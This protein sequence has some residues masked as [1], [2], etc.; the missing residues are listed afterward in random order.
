MYR[1]VWIYAHVVAGWPLQNVCLQ[2]QLAITQTVSNDFAFYDSAHVQISGQ[3]SG[4]DSAVSLIPSTANPN[5][6]EGPANLLPAPGKPY[7]LDIVVS[8]D[9]SGS[10]RTS[11]YT[12]ST[13][14][15]SHF[16]IAEVQALV[17]AQ[18]DTFLNTP[19]LPT[20]YNALFNDS[21]EIF[22][23]NR[24][25]W[26]AFL[27]KNQLT[28]FAIL[29]RTRAPFSEEDTLI[30]LNPPLDLNAHAVVTDYSEDVGGI[31]TTQFFGD[32]AGKG[33]SSFHGF[34]GGPPDSTQKWEF[35][36]THR[37]DYTPSLEVF[38]EANMM[39][40]L[41]ISNA[42]LYVGDTKFF[43]FATD[44]NYWPYVSNSIRGADD[45]R[46]RPTSNITHGQGV[47]VGM[48][49]DSLTLHTRALP[50]SVVWPYSRTSILACRSN[51]WEDSKGACQERLRDFC[52]DSLSTAA[53]CR[54]TAI[55]TALDSG[56]A[57]N[58]L[59]LPDTDQSVL[60][61]AQAMGERRQCMASDFP[62]ESWCEIPRN[63]CLVSTQETACKQELW[64]WCINGGWPIE[65]SYACG[66]G[67]VS[68]M[69]LQNKTSPALIHARDQWCATHKSDSQC[70]I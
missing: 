5:C 40:T 8:W 28:M 58:A 24:P 63:D 66:S 15:P 48:V 21:L 38:G 37:L 47:F 36:H 34:F 10:S 22:K 43:F 69:R 49:V 9:S 20:E 42:Y 53:D 27:F 26:D 31:L 60:D 13:K 44:S 3:F 61:S 16:H 59:M 70:K 6:F 55:A 57:W 30:L 2:P 62:S 51:N 64:D 41:F 4:H 67:L 54:T 32:D 23:T 45:S 68:W 46:I 39:D 33:A 29:G 11:H 50:G 56:L 14:T 12:A 17:V 18:P 35:G 1:G 19:D 52:V 7:S 25:A 65:T